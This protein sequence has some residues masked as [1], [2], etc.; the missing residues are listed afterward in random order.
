MHPNIYGPF[1]YLGL[2]GLAILVIDLV[3]EQGPA[4][5]LAF[6]ECAWHGHGMVSPNSPLFLPL[7]H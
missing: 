4:I 1:T 2:G 7:Q 5:S 6:G 3:T